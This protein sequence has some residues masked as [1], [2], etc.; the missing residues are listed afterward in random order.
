MSRALPILLL[1]AAGCGAPAGPLQAPDAQIL[2]DGKTLGAWKSVPYGGEGK[3]YVENGEIRIDSGVSLSG[4]QW[5]GE[6]PPR[7]NYEVALEAKKLEGNDFFCCV[8]FPIEKELCSF[9]A[10]GWGGGVVGISSIDGMNASENETSKVKDFKIGQWYAFRVRVT[11][12]KLEAWIDQEK[13]VDLELKDRRISIHP[14]VEMG[15][16]LGLANY[17]TSSAFR[18]IRLR[19]LD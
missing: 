17:G 5:T 8:I 3:A 7:T 6:A 18:N 10:G 13:M 2:F 9:V 11:P 16:P 14:A 1:L 12:A 19:K 4:V 15:G